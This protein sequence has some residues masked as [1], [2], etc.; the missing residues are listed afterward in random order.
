MS[1]LES[2]SGRWSGGGE[3]EGYIGGL[4]MHWEGLGMVSQSGE[5]LPIDN[6]KSKAKEVNWMM[7][8]VGFQEM[9]TVVKWLKRVTALGVDDIMRCW[10][11]V[12]IGCWK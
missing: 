9:F 2:E 10:R 5:D 11:M 4:A 6:L 3:E 1:N 7:E 12:G 8:P